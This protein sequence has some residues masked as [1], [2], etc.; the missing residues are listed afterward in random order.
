MSIY[1]EIETI[2]T[3]ELGSEEWEKN[4]FEEL[5]KTRAHIKEVQDLFDRIERGV[6][7]HH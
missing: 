1:N 5:E 6:L 2:E 3:P 7:F 4:F